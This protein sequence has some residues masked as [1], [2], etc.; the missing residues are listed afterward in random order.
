MYFS[1]F[2][3]PKYPQIMGANNTWVFT[4]YYNCCGTCHKFVVTCYKAMSKRTNVLGNL[5][6]N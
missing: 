4:V 5:M 1:Q 6:T 2:F 3:L